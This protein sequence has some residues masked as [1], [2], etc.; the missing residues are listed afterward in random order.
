MLRGI[1]LAFAVLLVS[2]LAGAA[3]AQDLTE[4][5]RVRLARR[6][7]RSVVSLSSSTSGASGFVV[8]DENWI[9][10]NDHFVEHARDSE[11]RALFASGTSRRVVIV[12]RDPDHDLAVLR[13]EPSMPGVVALDLADSDRVDVGQ[14]AFTF[15]SPRGLDWTLSEG[16]V[17]ARRDLGDHRRHW[18]RAIQTD[19]LIDHGSSGCPLVDGRGRVMGVVFRGHDGIGSAIPANYVR[20][21]LVRVRRLADRIARHEVATTAS[22]G[23]VGADCATATVAGVRVQRVLV[24]SEAERAGILGVESRAPRSAVAGTWSGQVI[25]AVDGRTIHTVMDL[26]AYLSTRERGASVRVTLREEHSSASTETT[27]SLGDSE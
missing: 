14:R 15:G 21:L 5:A 13:C 4:T 12:Q 9:V 11:I 6:L 24:G 27:V 20:D 2:G 18:A 3:V 22:I 23:I 26:D 10:T 16:I 17:S 7:R 8:G 1:T 25:T 19:A